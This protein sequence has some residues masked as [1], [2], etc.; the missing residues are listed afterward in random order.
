MIRNILRFYGE[1][2]LAPSPKPKLEDHTLSD[3]LDSLFNIFASTVLVEVE[4]RGRW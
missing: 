2:L 3:V 1:E 4:G